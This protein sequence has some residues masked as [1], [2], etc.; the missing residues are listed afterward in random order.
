MAAEFIGAQ[1][2]LGRLIIVRQEYLDSSSMIVIIIIYS[3]L[4][5]VVDRVIQRIEMPLTMWTGRN[6]QTGAVGSIVGS[7]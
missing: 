6:A 2:G 5:I 1:S 4:A 3:L 7:A